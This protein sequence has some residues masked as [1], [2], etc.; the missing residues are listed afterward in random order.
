MYEEKGRMYEE[1]K[2]RKVGGRRQT[3]NKR[4]NTHGSHQSRTLRGKKKERRETSRKVENRWR[5]RWE[6]EKENQN[7][8]QDF[9]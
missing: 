7:Q 9:K 2:G 3:R 4:K 8:G 6:R 5:G 1:K